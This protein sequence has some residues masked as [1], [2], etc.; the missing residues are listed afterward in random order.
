MEFVNID[1]MIDRDLQNFEGNNVDISKK[2]YDLK[3]RS[4]FYCTMML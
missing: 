1:S 2:Q 3:W 4:K